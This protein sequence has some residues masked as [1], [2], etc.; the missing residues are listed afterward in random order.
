MSAFFHVEHLTRRFG[1]LVAIDDVSFAV[2][3]GMTYSII[4]PN[5]AGKTT[6]FNCINGE[7]FAFNADRLWR[8]HEFF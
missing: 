6:M 1:G 7:L 2:E 5:G 4:G 3:R 8:M